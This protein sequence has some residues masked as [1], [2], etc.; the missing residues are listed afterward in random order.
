M[1]LRAGYAPVMMAAVAAGVIE[2]KLEN[3]GLVHSAG[4]RELVQMPQLAGLHRRTEHAGRR[5]SMTT[6]R[7]FTAPVSASAGRCASSPG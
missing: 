5:P 2:G 6:S 1:P 7:T 4:R 3:G